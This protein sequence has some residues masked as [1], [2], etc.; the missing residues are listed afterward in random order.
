M[1]AAVNNNANLVKTLLKAG[2][3]VNAQTEVFI[4]LF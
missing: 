2:A 3:H 1:W 4:L